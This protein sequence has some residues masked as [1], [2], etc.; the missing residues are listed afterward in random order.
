MSLPVAPEVIHNGKR[1]YSAKVDIWSLGCVV[2]EMLS[3]RRPW[4]TE[5][6]FAALYKA[7]RSFL[8][9]TCTDF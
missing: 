1:G 7:C 2:V 3:G 6:M 4:N 8:E 9:R 5:Q